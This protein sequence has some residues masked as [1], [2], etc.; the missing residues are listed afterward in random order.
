MK[1]VGTP[2]DVGNL[3]AFLATTEPCF[4]T[5]RDFIIDGFQFNI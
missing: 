1:R 3:V 2:V 5:G 4:I